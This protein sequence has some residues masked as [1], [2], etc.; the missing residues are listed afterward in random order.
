MKKLLVVL[1]MLG[2]MVVPATADILVDDFT[3]ATVKNDT[4]GVNLD[5]G[6][7]EGRLSGTTVEASGGVGDSAYLQMDNDSSGRPT[8]AGWMFPLW[9][10]LALERTTNSSSTTRWSALPTYYKFQLVRTMAAPLHTA[11]GWVQQT[12]TSIG[13]LR[14]CHHWTSPMWMYSAI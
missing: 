12:V 4:N 6:L 14:V 9:W 10:G 8:M 13:P 5:A 1:A 2:L 3:G 7:W 11:T